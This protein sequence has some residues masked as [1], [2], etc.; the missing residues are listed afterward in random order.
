[1]VYY[2]QKAGFQALFANILS[3]PMIQI[4][5]KISVLGSFSK[6]SETTF[7]KNQDQVLISNMAVCAYMFTKSQPPT[8]LK[9]HC[10]GRF[11]KANVISFA[12]YK[13]A[14]QNT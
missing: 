1:M 14:D 7:C 12:I 8:P 11:V 5:K 4:F 10:S 6:F 2:L 3:M 9:F 13:S